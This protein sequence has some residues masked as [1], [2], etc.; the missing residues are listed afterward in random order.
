MVLKKYLM[1]NKRIIRGAVGYAITRF[2][3]ILFIDGW[4][5]INIKVVLLTV[6]ESLVFTVI[7]NYLLELTTPPNKTKKQDS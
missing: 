2:L 4:Q 1:V 7:L 6:V 5:H 3:F